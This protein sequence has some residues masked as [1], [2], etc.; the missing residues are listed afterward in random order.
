VA[1][2][3]LVGAILTPRLAAAADGLPVE[4]FHDKRV[5]VNAAGLTTGRIQ[6]SLQRFCC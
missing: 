5:R 6:A 2:I 1:V 3:A 4:H